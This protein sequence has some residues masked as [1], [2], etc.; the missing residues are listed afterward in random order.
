MMRDFSYKKMCKEF[1][2]KVLDMIVINLQKIKSKTIWDNLN[3]IR[4]IQ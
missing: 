4:I 1:V 3:M 2:L